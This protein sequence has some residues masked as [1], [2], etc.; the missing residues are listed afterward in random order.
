MLLARR[1]FVVYFFLKES[2]GS[3]YERTSLS[4]V[5]YATVHEV[6]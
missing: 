4:L 5:G 1:G 3:L 2:L 6:I